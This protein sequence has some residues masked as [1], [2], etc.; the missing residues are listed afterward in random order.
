MS[1][2]VDVIGAENIL[3]AGAS[4]HFTARKFYTFRRSVCLS[5]LFVCLSVCMS[6]SLPLSV[7]LSVSDRPSVF[8]HVYRLVTGILCEK[9][10]LE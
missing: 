5:C 6:G 3:L 8:F 10:E 1:L 4:V 7:C 2:K 9:D